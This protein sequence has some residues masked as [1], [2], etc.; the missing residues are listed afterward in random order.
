MVDKK[1][2]IFDTKIVKIIVFDAKQQKYFMATVYFRLSTKASSNGTSELMIRFSASR[3]H[4][5][6]AKTGIF[7]P[8]DRWSKK[9]TLIIPKIETKEREMLLKLKDKIDALEKHVFQSFEKANIN[10]LSK[11]WFIDCVDRFNKPD[12]Q[13]DNLSDFFRAYDKYLK[14][15][16][17][18][19]GRLRSIKVVYRILQR[20]ELYCQKV[21]S[22]YKIKFSEINKEFITDLRDYITNEYKL[23][24]KYPEIIKAVPE[25]RAPEQRGK[26]TIG[27]KLKMFRAFLNWCVNNDYLET[28]PF[29]RFP[30]GDAVFGT[31]IYITIAERNIIYSHD[32]TDQPFLAKQRDIF[33]FQCLIGCRVGDLLSLKKNNIINGAVEYIAQKTK[34]GD[35]LTVR[36]PLNDQAKEIIAKYADSEGDKLLPFIS[37]Q[38]YNEAIKDIF[39]LAKITRNVTVLNSITREPEQVP[40]N[41][42]ASSHLARRTFIGNIYKQV[43][44]PNL[45]G[46]LSGHK[47]GSRAFARYRNIDDDIKSELVNLLL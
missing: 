14:T 12:T 10:I 43:K 37:S 41:K 33:V 23:I 18:S 31:P 11:Q 40:I 38:K 42:I 4:V 15:Q 19:S 35:P 8:V 6:R 34:N 27:A 24:E 13:V 2:I 20:Y 28:N 26:N 16:Q 22:R 17:L 39:T 9:N 29:K 5:Y 25:S 44:D 1:I 21:N 7:I 30:I 45:V 32:F 47:D 3:E 46:S 36:V